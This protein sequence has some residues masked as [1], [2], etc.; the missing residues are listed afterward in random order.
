MP[1]AAV[2]IG[3]YTVAGGVAAGG[4]VGGLMVAGGFFTAVGAIAKDNDA[5]QL[6][7]LLTLAGGV[8]SL[9]SGA[10]NSTAD[11]VAK[12]AAAPAAATPA[13][14]G[15]QT[16]PTGGV[17]Q[18]SQV[19]APTESEL[20]GLGASGPSAAAPAAPS[21]AAAHP[22]QPAAQVSTPSLLSPSVAS[23][24]APTVDMPSLAGS[25]QT[26]QLGNTTS[27]LA[28]QPAQ[29]TM[30]GSM[31]DNLKAGAGGV[32]DYI[33]NP[34]NARSVQLGSGMLKSVADYYGQKE[35]LADK[36]KAEE[37]AIAR[38]RARRSASLRGLSMPIYKK[39]G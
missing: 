6:G 35:L 11:S 17:E 25:T 37:D 31:W 9:A 7:G 30:L 16:V 28:T 36:Y 13:E 22:V 14:A 32:G 5:M 1:V 3:A 12:E 33:N 23:P 20:A 2:L 39:G 34:A 8:G 24:L 38:E 15:A 19:T 29:P 26:A 4:I 21:A 18:A 27:A 10:M